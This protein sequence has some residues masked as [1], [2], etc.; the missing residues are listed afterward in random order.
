MSDRLFFDT[1][2]LLDHLFDRD[3][4]ADNATEL[5]S[6][7]GFRKSEVPVISP[8]AYLTGRSEG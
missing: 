3:R 2:V 5:W 1:N 4:F 6:M 8:A 7:A